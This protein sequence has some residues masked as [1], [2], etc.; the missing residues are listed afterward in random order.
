MQATTLTEADV[1]RIA[2]LAR[3]ELTD[4]EVIRLTPQLEAIV[5]FVKQLQELN[6]EGV[7][8]LSQ[9]IE[10]FNRYADDE[11]SPGLTRES[12]LSVAPKRDEEC[13]LVPPVLTGS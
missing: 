11:L 8:P 7:E 4:E 10:N 9:A 3:L 1:R 5:G 6:T 2:L 12:A 13:F